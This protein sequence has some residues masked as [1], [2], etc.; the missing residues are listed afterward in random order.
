MDQRRSAAPRIPPVI[1]P[2]DVS[3]SAT[4]CSLYPCLKTY[5]AKVESGQMVEKLVSQEK[6]DVY[7]SRTGWDP[8][9][10][11]DDRSDPA[12]ISPNDA[13]ERSNPTSLLSVRSPCRVDR[14]LYT[15]ENISTSARAVTLARWTFGN[16]ARSED[17]IYEETAWRL[18]RTGEVNITAPPECI[19]GMQS[20]G[21]HDLEAHDLLE[22]MLDG[23]CTTLGEYFGFTCFDNRMQTDTLWLD[24][25]A[26][27]QRRSHVELGEY[28]DKIAESL[29]RQMRMGKF[30][31]SGREMP[32]NE[33]RSD[34]E[35]EVVIGDA[36]Q[37][38]TCFAVNMNWLV[39][40]T[41]I[42]MLTL[43]ILAWTI[44]HGNAHGD[45]VWK[46]S[47]LP[48]VYHPDRTVIV[49]QQDDGTIGVPVPETEPLLWKREM[50]KDSKTVNVRMGRAEA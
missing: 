28:F 32:G 33:W 8:I 13:Y 36:W 17:E 4:L 50:E 23:F 19:Y 5:R 14:D 45:A 27:L 40:S 44:W 38:A 18:N 42:T 3:V 20:Q 7:G 43:I 34:A 16:V 31:V 12:Y 41:G 1:N 21:W 15:S 6:L 30:E 37:A 9:P 29:T 39:L 26:R 48:L 46:S 10:D 25:F 11:D 47:I 22:T 49:V 24:G 2:K 35:K